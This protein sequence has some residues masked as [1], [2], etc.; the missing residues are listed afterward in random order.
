VIRKTDLVFAA[1]M[2]ITV[3]FVGCVNTTSAE[4]HNGKIISARAEPD[5]LVSGQPMSFVITVKNTGTVETDFK[6]DISPLPNF[7]SG[8]FSLN[9]GNTKTL[10]INREALFSLLVGVVLVS[11][12]ISTDSTVEVVKE[13]DY[14][15]VDYIGKLEDGTVFDTSVKDAAIEAGI[16]NQKRDYQPLEF[17]VGAGEMIG[18]FDK[19]VVGMAVGEN[20]AL[21]I[22][23][24]EAY[25]A[26]REDMLITSPIEEL[27]AAGITPVVGQKISTARGQVGTIT[28]ITDTEVVIDFN[29]ELAG[30]TLFFDIKLLDIQLKQFVGP[31]EVP[32]APPT[33][34]PTEAPRETP[35]PTP[36]P[37]ASIPPLYLI[38]AAAVIVIILIAGIFVVRRKTTS[39]TKQKPSRSRKLNRKTLSELSKLMAYIL[40]HDKKQKFRVDLDENCYAKIDQLVKAISSIG[41]W[42]WVNRKHIEEVAAKSFYRGKRRFVIK[43]DKIKAT[44]RI[45]RKCPSTPTP[46]PKPTPP[47][48]LEQKEIER[49][50]V[51]QEALINLDYH[52]KRV[53]EEVRK[54]FLELREKI[55]RLGDVEERIKESEVSYN[56]KNRII[57]ADF[58]GFHR[59]H[60][61]MYLKLNKDVEDLR[62]ETEYDEK[63]FGI[64][65][66]RRLKLT[67]DTDTD[68]TVELVKQAIK[69]TTARDIEKKEAPLTLERAIYDPCK[70]DFIEGRL[71]RMK[72]WINRYDP[73]AYWFAISIQNNTDRAIEEWGVELETSSALTIKEA[74]V[75]GIDYKIELHET[76]PEP[77]KNKYA[78]GVPKEYGIVIPKGGAQRIYFKL[79]AEK[80][81][82]T[83]EI[84]GVFKSVL[85]EVPIRAKEFKYL[86]DTGVSPE[87]VKAELKKTFSEKDAAM[88]A[89]SFK[90][91][92]Q[93]DRMCDQ[94][95]KT[96]DYLDK[97]S[98]LK[99][100][101]EGFSDTFTKQVAE[102]SRFMKQEQLEYLDDE[103][104]VKVRRF[105]T[106]LVD[107]WINA[108]L[109]K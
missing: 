21:T 25:G 37:F 30:K 41:K 33:E 4:T 91:V 72:E 44:Y 92:Q 96:E 88:L 15:Q 109:K 23:P 59:D 95:A 100:Y 104:K 79:R 8:K 71:P 2:I 6:L 82:T 63:G 39:N 66:K 75:E 17:T 7:L 19:G 36:S 105:C 56:I 84:S 81:K 65:F 50:K 18:G 1:L 90:I 48:S 3:L 61:W 87:A 27:T 31:N 53:N 85:G 11:G 28:N 46:T 60:I 74:R 62:R 103:Y 78:I 40:R 57:F 47:P 58:F 52:L 14:V 86:C 76:H 101:T 68:Y 34:A 20:K 108:F 98:S 16:Y 97:L 80:P 29:H 106:N 24:E 99:G 77:Y 107:V 93:I 38:G 5:L 13:G 9:A 89:L 73:G 22:P 43:E 69:K 45:T 10:S 51:K 67:K 102:F 35:T 49:Q 94:E 12:G 55:L 42:R 70:R 83:Y 26:Y 32:T 54:V 64:G